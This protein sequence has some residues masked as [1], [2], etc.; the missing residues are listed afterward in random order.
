MRLHICVFGTKQLA[1]TLNG[2]LFDGIEKTMVNNGGISSH[3]RAAFNLVPYRAFP[4]VVGE[5]IS[6]RSGLREQVL[7]QKLRRLE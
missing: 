2:N 4:S 6:H 7:C 1:G 3:T 5:R